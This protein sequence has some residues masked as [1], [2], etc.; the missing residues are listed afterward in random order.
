MT[1]VEAISVGPQKTL[2][3]VRVGETYMVVGVSRDQITYLREID[4]TELELKQQ[5]ELMPFSKIL[6]KIVR[7]DSVEQS[8]I[9]SGVD[10]DEPIEKK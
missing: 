3:I 8:H 2:Q 5:E 10:R 7:K 4:S 9:E 1:I 6:D